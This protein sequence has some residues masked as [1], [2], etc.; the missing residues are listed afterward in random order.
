MKM[1][2]LTISLAILSLLLLLNTCRMGKKI[3][4]Q[5]G[6]ITQQQLDNQ[7]IQTVVNKQ[8]ETISRQKV[9]ITSSQQSINALTDT[10]FDLKKKDAKNTNTI[11]YLR[12]HQKFKLDSIL[13]PYEVPASVNERLRFADSI[14]ALC[15]DVINVIES[16]SVYV[17]AETSFRNNYINFQARI[18]KSGLHIDSLVINDTIQTRFVEKKRGFLKRPYVEVQMMHSNPLF[19]NEGMQSVIYQPKKKNF[20]KRV[21]LPVAV[22]VGAGLLIAK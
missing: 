2:I 3:D 15:K 14:E 10:V 9:I 11:A 16:N 8:G 6:V 22:G 1:R 12:T 7:T 4:E 20:F 13:I 17:P 18:E 21:L 19:S 5:D